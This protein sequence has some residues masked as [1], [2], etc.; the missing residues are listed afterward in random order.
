MAIEAKHL[1][2]ELKVG[3]DKGMIAT[4]EGVKA[5]SEDD[6]LGLGE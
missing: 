4:V 1:P 3:V 2:T 6:P 5:T